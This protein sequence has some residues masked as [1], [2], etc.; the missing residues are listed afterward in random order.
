MP[1]LLAHEWLAETGG[2][3]NCFEHLRGTFPDAQ[4]MCLWNDAPNRFD[5]SVEESW[6]AKTPLRRSKPLALPFLPRVWRS[7]DLKGFDRVVASSHAFSHH[8]AFAAARVGL[9]AYAYIYT[10]ARY[11]WTP[12]FDDRGKSF[13][14]RAGRNHLRRV[15]KAHTSTNVKYAAISEF[16]RQRI[17]DTWEMPATIIYPPVEIEAVQSCDDWR[18]N[19][20]GSE[21]EMLASLPEGFVLGASR[22]VEYKRLDSTIEVGELLGRPVVLAGSGPEED[23]LRDRAARSYVPVIFVGRVSDAALFAL[24]QEASLF[25]FMPIEDFGIMPVEAMALGTPVLVR[26]EGGARETVEILKGGASANP[27]S[28]QDLK[29]A[30][31]AAIECDTAYAIDNAHIFSAARFRSEITEWCSQ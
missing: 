4:A 5:N 6:I 2:S 27:Q 24:Y 31:E 18:N 11:V 10:P 22:F 17:A 12:E 23:R 7:V 15:D 8:L 1:T 29:D 26:D 14:A 25:V 3:E 16:V 19:T 9:P 21:G 28:P 30:A 13:V 20:E